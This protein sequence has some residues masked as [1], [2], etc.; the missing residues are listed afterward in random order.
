MGAASE[1]AVVVGLAVLAANRSIVFGAGAG[2]AGELTGLIGFANMIDRTIRIV[3]TALLAA[4]AFMGDF[5]MLA[6]SHAAVGIGPSID[7]AD[8]IPQGRANARLHTSADQTVLIHLADHAVGAHGV[9]PANAYTVHV[10]PL[11]A[12]V[13]HANRGGAVFAERAIRVDGTLLA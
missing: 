4:F 9:G 12:V 1:A 5:D 2:Q 10:V 13:G 8:G 7:A 6:F 11:A 3:V